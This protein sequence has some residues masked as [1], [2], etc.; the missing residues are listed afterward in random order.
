MITQWTTFSLSHFIVKTSSQEKT[1]FHNPWSRNLKVFDGKAS[2]ARFLTMLQILTLSPI[3]PNY[4]FITFTNFPFSRSFRV[5]IIHYT[6]I[7]TL[8]LTNEYPLLSYWNW[9]NPLFISAY[10]SKFNQY[11]L[12][13]VIIYTS[14]SAWCPFLR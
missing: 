11:I 14:L 4:Y 12:F 7:S 5:C 8:T 6:L 1:F 2:L 10:I 3:N 13:V 9:Q